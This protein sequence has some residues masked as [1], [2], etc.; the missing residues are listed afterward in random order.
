MGQ[1]QRSKVKPSCRASPDTHSLALTR[2]LPILSTTTCI[3]SQSSPPPHLS[4]LSRPCTTTHDLPLSLVPFY[5]SP[6]LHLLFKIPLLL[7]S[8]VNF[9]LI[10]TFLS[11]PHLPCSDSRGLSPHSSLLRSALLISFFLLPPNPSPCQIWTV[12]E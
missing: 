6:F 2:H 1:G 7:S 3:S 11:S 8:Q 5:I 9:T 4:S 10:P 12:G